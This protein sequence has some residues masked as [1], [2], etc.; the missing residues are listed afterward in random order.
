M[1]EKCVEKRGFWMGL[2]IC[3]GCKNFDSDCDM[4]KLEIMD[5]HERGGFE[6]CSYFEACDGVSITPLFHITSGRAEKSASPT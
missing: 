6:C 4:C 2:S 5:W 3:L 1:P